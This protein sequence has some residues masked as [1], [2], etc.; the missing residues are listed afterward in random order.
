MS[1]ECMST[2]TILLFPAIHQTMGAVS[3]TSGRVNDDVI[4]NEQT[5]T[6]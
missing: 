4:I 3:E 2:S 6:G 5:G 1:D